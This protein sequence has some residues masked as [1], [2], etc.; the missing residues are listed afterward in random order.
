MDSVKDTKYANRARRP[1]TRCASWPDIRRDRIA[2]SGAGAARRLARAAYLRL[3][4]GLF[5]LAPELARPC[6][7]Q[8]NDA[9]FGMEGGPPEA[10]RAREIR[11]VPQSPNPS[12]CLSGRLSRLACR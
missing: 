11:P 8:E 4:C 10:R 3:T 9:P 6:V 1:P 2:T 7:Q 12:L 5:D